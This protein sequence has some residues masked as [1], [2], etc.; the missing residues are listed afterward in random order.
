MPKYQK[1]NSLNNYRSRMSKLGDHLVKSVILIYACYLTRGL[2]VQRCIIRRY[3]PQIK[4]M[5][6]PVICSIIRNGLKRK[7]A[8]GASY[9]LLHFPKFVFDFTHIFPG[10]GCDNLK[11]KDP[12]LSQHQIICPCWARHNK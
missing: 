5:A 1:N 9:S 10:H 3:F 11:K 4:L 6:E 7:L 2:V 12:A 8:W